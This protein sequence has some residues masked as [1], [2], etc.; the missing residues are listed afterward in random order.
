MYCFNCFNIEVSK[1]GRST[2]SRPNMF[3]LEIGRLNILPTRT[4]YLL[5]PSC[6]RQDGNPD[7][8]K[9]YMYL[10][11]PAKYDPC[12]T[13]CRTKLICTPFHSKMSHVYP[14]W[15]NPTHFLLTQYQTSPIPTRPNPYQMQT[16]LTQGYSTQIWY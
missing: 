15:L 3:R 12:L 5:L 9:L 10:V 14:S 1:M 11:R 6:T 8:S 2:R 7:R 13:W 16:I 4:Q